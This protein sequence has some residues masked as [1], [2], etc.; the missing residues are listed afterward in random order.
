MI[1]DDS[2][3]ARDAERL[4]RHLARQRVE[5]GEEPLGWYAWAE[6]LYHSETLTAAGLRVGEWA[7]EMLR[8]FLGEDFPQ[9]ATEAR[10]GHPILL[11]SCG[12]QT[13]CLGPFVVCSNSPRTSR[14]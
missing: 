9:R 2:A 6:P 14:F 4:A 8:R 11:P 7:V 13:M 10:T 1:A 5:R 3:S 12:P